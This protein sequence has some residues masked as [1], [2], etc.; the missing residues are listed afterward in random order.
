MKLINFFSHKNGETKR[1]IN[2]TV[3]HKL[4]R[5]MSQQWFE[6]DLWLFQQ[7]AKVLDAQYGVSLIGKGQQSMVAHLLHV[8]IINSDQSPSADS[9]L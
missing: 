7:I 4:F 3:I 8:S 2:Q 5:L 6:I 9:Y 1:K